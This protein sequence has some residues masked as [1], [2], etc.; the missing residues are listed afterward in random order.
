MTST[1]LHRSPTLRA[2]GLEAQRRVSALGHVLGIWAHPDDETYLSGGLLAL[3]AANGQR[4]TCVTA[5]AGEQG[6]DDPERWPPD[7]L[8]RHR[9]IELALALEVLEV[10]E[11]HWLGLA[12]GRCHEA[13][14]MLNIARL[15][16]IMLRTRPDTIITFGPDGIT[17]HR[18]HR[19]VGWWAS[20]AADAYGGAEL[21]HAAHTA[22]WISDNAA[23]HDELPVFEP[24]YPHAAPDEEVVVD[25]DLADDVLDRK[26]EALEAQRTQTAPVI[27]AFGHDRWRSWVARET[28]VLAP[29]PPG[30]RRGPGAVG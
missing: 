20:V 5:T 4:T 18:D 6:T 3:A 7:R 26:V 29:R 25:L 14:A 10:D 8:A 27:D 2:E 19:T 23:L 22:D 28:F 21:L 9:R 24:G 17:G 11:H 12:D 13:D 30:G 16:G 1:A 15:L